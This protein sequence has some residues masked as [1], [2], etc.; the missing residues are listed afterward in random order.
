MSFEPEVREV[1]LALEQF[2]RRSPAAEH[3]A[4]G[5]RESQQRSDVPQGSRGRRQDRE[6]PA[7]D[8]VGDRCRRWTILRARPI[9]WA[10]ACP[11]QDMGTASSR[12]S[13]SATLGRSP[14]M[15]AA[16]TGRNTT[17]TAS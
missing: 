13:P 12:A 15:R 2:F 1:R 11:G 8:R 5:D 10:S 7:D 4:D 6:Q 16:T 3:D 17:A 14:R 9:P